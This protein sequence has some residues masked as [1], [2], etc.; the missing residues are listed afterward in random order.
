[1]P[2]TDTPVDGVGRLLVTVDADALN[3]CG[4]VLVF[5]QHLLQALTRLQANT[6]HDLTQVSSLDSETLM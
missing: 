6:E 4:Q 5:L 2:Q 3:P 1:M